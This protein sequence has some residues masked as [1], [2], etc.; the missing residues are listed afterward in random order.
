[1]KP[2]TIRISDANGSTSLADYF[3]ADEGKVFVDRS[4]CAFAYVESAGISDYTELDAE[5]AEE[6]TTEDYENA[7]ADLGV[8]A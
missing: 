7:L 6:A 3:F 5:E 1:M 2:G 8:H 4:G